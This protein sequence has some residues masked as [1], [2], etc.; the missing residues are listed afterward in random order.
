M[1]TLTH[2]NLFEIALNTPFNQLILLCRTDKQFSQLCR[3]DHFWQEK[4]QFDFPNIDPIK[5]TNGVDRYVSARY[6]NIIDEGD[7]KDYREIKRKLEQAVENNN[8]RLVT[9]LI[10]II[11]KYYNRIYPEWHKSTNYIRELGKRAIEFNNFEIL[12]YLLETL[13]EIEGPKKSLSKNKELISHAVSQN[14]LNMLKYIVEYLRTID[15]NYK[16]PQHIYNI[17]FK[18]PEIDQ[19]VF[20]NIA[21]Q[22]I[23]LSGSEGLFNDLSSG[24]FISRQG[25]FNISGVH[26]GLSNDMSSWREGLFND[27]Y[28]VSTSIPIDM[29]LFKDLVASFMSGESNGW[30][31]GTFR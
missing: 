13:K 8:L 16:I 27:P 7:I 18:T 29:G 14:N 12:H 3:D 1:E 6:M 30:D 5:G 2:N 20:E 17:R 24:T 10:P 31:Y 22:S 26:E 23:T 21:K 11:G 25:P 28:D 4:T 15:P 9:I 19:Y